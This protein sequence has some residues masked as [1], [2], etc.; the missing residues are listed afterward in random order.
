[1]AWTWAQVPTPRAHPPWRGTGPA[2]AIVVG[3]AAPGALALR[4]GSALQA[5][6]VLLVGAAAL[7]VGA[8]SSASWAARAAIAL[9]AA[10]TT[11]V[12]AGIACGVWLWLALAV[13]WWVA[14]DR[15]PVP[16]LPRA[17]A[18]TRL[19]ASVLAAL[20]A[21]VLLTGRHPA[22]AVA[23][24]AV[25]TFLPLISRLGGGVVPRLLD[26]VG[27]AAGRAV[28]T[29]CFGA[30]GIVVVLLPWV[31]QRLLR[32]DPL[33]ARPGWARRARR[34]LQPASPWAADPQLV[35]PP[36]G[37][38]IR[39]GA[40]AI[41]ATLVV[42]LSVPAS[43]SAIID[44]A[45]TDHRAP[46]GFQVQASSEDTEPTELRDPVPPGVRA[47]PHKLGEPLAAHAGDPWFTD[48][49]YNTAGGWGFNPKSAWRTI[50]VHRVRDF[51]SRWINVIDGHRQSWAPPPCRCRRLRV[52]MYGGSTTFGLDQRDEHTIASELARVAS[53]HGIILDMSNRGLPGFLQWMEGE[54]LSWDLSQEAAPDLVIMY[55][56]VNDAWSTNGVN[57]TGGDRK[58]MTDPTSV[59]LWNSSGRSDPPPPPSPPGAALGH[60]RSR[61][62]VNGIA[63]AHLV[64]D[65]YQRARQLSQMVAAEHHV[66][67][68]YFWQPTRFS[69]PLVPSEPHYDTDRENGSRLD[70]QLVADLMP[71]DIPTMEDTFDGTTEP[72][73]VDDVHHN[74]RGARLV[75]EKLY[76]LLA[77]EL[78]RLLEE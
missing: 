2:T 22:R 24:F 27:T 67:I 77:P 7:G 4:S 8:R 12:I 70:Q 26:R 25:V 78:H 11:A 14:Q 16:G 44:L 64:I 74:E 75:A 71:K 13:A 31:V 37:P 61:P 56:G 59:D 43:R 29:V 66:P 28:S 47:A 53:E 17:D 30:L 55:D 40:A 51:R 65:R 54:H 3:L 39:A 62:S 19:P 18:G 52:W 36:A 35:A 45:T 15:P 49:S 33:A 50:D 48:G 9:A 73:F 60:V 5:M 23:L 76:A 57:Q 32:L 21:A 58:A 1:M 6:A 20:S 68:R 10:A 42:A 69:R 38:R 72:L 41:V 63:Y 46:T 34:S